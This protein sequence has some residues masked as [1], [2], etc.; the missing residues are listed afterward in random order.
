MMSSYVDRIL[1]YLGDREPLEVLAATPSR[2]EDFFWELGD[3][4]L[5]RAAAPGKWSARTI[6]SHIADA[7]IAMAF[8]FRQALSE[9]H[10][11]VQPYDQDAWT[12]RDG[13]ADASLALE[14]F[15]AVRLWNLGLLR[16]LPPAEFDRM[17]SH[18]ERGEE[19]LGLMVRLLAG[20][21]LNHIAQLETIA[22]AR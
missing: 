18:P 20:H 3:A 5:E 19:S 6:F 17:T 22:Q 15:R 7:E 16:S 21:D 4:G 2:L 9:E 10:H 14:V 1:R 11:R 8:R 12:A 13:S